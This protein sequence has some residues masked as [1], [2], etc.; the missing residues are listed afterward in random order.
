MKTKLIVFPNNDVIL[1]SDEKIKE[2]WEG[3]AYKADVGGYDIYDTVNKVIK[4]RVRTNGIL[5][6][7]HYTG[8]AWYDDA[9]I[10]I[11]SNYIPN[12]PKLDLSLID[13]GIVNVEKLSEDLV[14]RETYAREDSPI[15]KQYEKYVKIGFNECSKLNRTKYWNL[16]NYYYPIH[17][18][19]YAIALL[20]DNNCEENEAL[21]YLNDAKKHIQLLPSI[22]KYDVE[23]EMEYRDLVG[24]WYLYED[25]LGKYNPDILEMPNRLRPRIV[26]NIIRVTKII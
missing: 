15:R 5:Y 4:E 12:L 18:L 26:D 25:Y 19:D 17:A 10:I 3:I 23:I 2:G 7:H 16:N 9:K 13:I 22:K 21:A 8:N 11:A 6:N 14:D 24:Y 20:K 1:I